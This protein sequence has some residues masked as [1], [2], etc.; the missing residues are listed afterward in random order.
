MRDVIQLDSS[1]RL[2]QT[3]VIALPIEL[4]HYVTMLR[5]SKL[6]HS[7]FNRKPKRNTSTYKA[8]T[9]SPFYNLRSQT[10]IEWQHLCSSSEPIVSTTTVWTLVFITDFLRTRLDNTVL[11][12][13]GLT[14]N[15]SSFVLVQCS[16]LKRCVER[17]DWRDFVGFN[18][19]DKK[20]LGGPRCLLLFFSATV[21][22]IKLKYGMFTDLHFP[23]YFY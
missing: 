7:V 14:D 10:E 9:K 16:V 1:Q 20:E 19:I 6:F 2:Y 17:Y 5:Y 13:V 18:I 12:A 3:M 21:I 8:Q 4:T 23:R 15:S 11:F 22:N